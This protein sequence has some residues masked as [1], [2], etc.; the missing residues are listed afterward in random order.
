MW[1]WKRNS[2]NASLIPW[3]YMTAI[4]F[5]FHQLILP[6]LLPIS[7]DC[8]CFY[9]SLEHQETLQKSQRSEIAFFILSSTLPFPPT[10]TIIM[11]AWRISQTFL[12]NLWRSVTTSPIYF[13]KIVVRK[14]YRPVLLPKA[15]TASAIATAQCCLCIT[16]KSTKM[17][18]Q[19]WSYT[20]Y[21]DLC[22]CWSSGWQF[23]S[24]WIWC[25]SWSSLS[26]L[27]SH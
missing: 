17:L 10:K 9:K 23:S 5:I 6:V 18:N 27:K 4:N 19:H 24:W 3:A 8:C 16:D 12:F 15:G 11:P 14:I 26:D 21:I 13:C 20:A 1:H 2:T 25:I 7:D 22:H